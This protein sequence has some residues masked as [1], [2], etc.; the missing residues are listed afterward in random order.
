MAVTT[1]AGDAFSGRVAPDTVAP[2]RRQNDFRIAIWFLL[3]S[4]I[5]L[6]AFLVFP[7]FAS[8]G[9]SFTNWT[10]IGTTKFVGI[11]NYVTMLTVDPVFWTVVWNTVFF[12]VEYLALN[13]VI[14]LGLAVWISNLRF[15]KRLF[16][17]IFF[18]PTFTP[19]I[20][21][22]VV[23]L[24]IFTPGGLMDWLFNLLHLPIGNSS[25]SPSSPCS[26]W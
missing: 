22:S 20:G 15:G 18:L 6:F 2:A 25:P 12:T 3:P 4:A 17:L 24:L 16:R 9:L 5:G 13:L 23:W 26:R 1:Q 21:A 11:R 7:L 19:M 14:S 8:L 10:L